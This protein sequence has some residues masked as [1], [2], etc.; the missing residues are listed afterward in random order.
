MWGRSDRVIIGV[1]IVAIV[2][3]AGV[4][5]FYFTGPT[6]IEPEGPA[7]T[8]SKMAPSGSNLARVEVYRGG[9]YPKERSFQPFEK[10]GI[11]REE[12]KY[13]AHTGGYLI[14]TFMLE[15]SFDEER[16]KSELEN[17]GYEKSTYGGTNF[18]KKSDTPVLGFLNAKIICGSEEGFKK[19]VDTYR[20]KAKSF[21]DDKKMR[22][23]LSKVKY[24]DIVWISDPAKRISLRSFK[25]RT[26]TPAKWDY[27]IL[28]VLPSE[29]N[30]MNWVDSMENM[31]EERMKYENYTTIVNNR[32]VEI[33]INNITEY[34]SPL[35]NFPNQN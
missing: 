35:E 4:S 23:I 15:G 12:V 22:R 24:E 28:R 3:L 29:K 30:I 34:Q 33:V 7:A 26:T 8:F 27:Q 13:I 1:V 20:G 25:I 9:H 18:W 5:F 16:L 32:T 2:F 19:I 21:Y 31:I 10:L 6:G 17:L 14:P 11:N